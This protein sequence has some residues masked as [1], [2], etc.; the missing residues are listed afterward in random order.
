M[1]LN[2]AITRKAGGTARTGRAKRKQ[3]PL[4][5]RVGKYSDVSSTRPAPSS[6]VTLGCIGLGGCGTADLRTLVADQHVQ[7]VALSGVDTGSRHYGGRK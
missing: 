4:G 3:I 2:N 5:V 1:H 6:R 7:V